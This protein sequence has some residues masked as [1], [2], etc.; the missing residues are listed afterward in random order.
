MR[1]AQIWVETVV[2]TLIGLGL[3]GIVLAF[4]T[5]KI[6]EY[7]DRS[8]IEHSISSLNLMDSKIQ[9]VLQAPLNTR[10]VEFTLKRGDLY[11][12]AEHD[13]LYFVLEESNVLYSQPDIETSLGRIKILTEQGRKTHR[14]TLLLNY[15]IDLDYENDQA[16]RKYSSA[17]TPY[18]FSFTNLGY[19]DEITGSKRQIVFVKE[20]SGA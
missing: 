5:P 15:T 12:N 20:L 1:K 18:R 6:Q 17:A 14:V 13:S 16:I 2:Y 7:R 4:V 3:I 10:V 11:F 8:I 9:E 19:T